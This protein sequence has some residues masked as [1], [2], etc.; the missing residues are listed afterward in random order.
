MLRPLEKKPSA[1]GSYTFGKQTGRYRKPREIS[2]NID[3]REN[4]L[5]SIRSFGGRDNLRKIRA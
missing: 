5:E 1:D 4:L 2:T 3:P